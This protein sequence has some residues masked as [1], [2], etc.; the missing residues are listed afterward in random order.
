MYGSRFSP[1][2]LIGGAILIAV[3]FVGLILL[4]V[5]DRLT[6]SPAM[7]RHVNDGSDKFFDER[8]SVVKSAV[9]SLEELGK[10]CDGP[11]P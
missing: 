10:N 8:G 6:E 11:L 1:E 5:F 2:R 3:I 4:E 7:K 9:H